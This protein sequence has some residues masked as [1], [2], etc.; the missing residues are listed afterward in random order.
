MTSL[1]RP[2]LFLHPLPPFSLSTPASPLPHPA[3][4]PN[5]TNVLVRG[6]GPYTKNLGAGGGAGVPQRESA[7]RHSPDTPHPHALPVLGTAPRLPNALS[8]VCRTR[9]RGVWGGGAS[10]R[11]GVGGEGEGG[12]GPEGQSSPFPH[13]PSL[14]PAGYVYYWVP[15]EGPAPRHRGQG[16]GS[17][18]G[19]E[20]EKGN[21]HGVA[22]PWHGLP[23]LNPKPFLSLQ[24]TTLLRDNCATDPQGLV[25]NSHSPPPNPWARCRTA[26]AVHLDGCPRHCAPLSRESDRSG[27]SLPAGSIT[28]GI[29]P[30]LVA[31]G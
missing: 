30:R 12:G 22:A 18:R 27:S 8:H 13:S 14:L 29:P 25:Y 5:S 31:P 9:G 21:A 2:P 6:P 11:R 1:T 26:G 20:N 15:R 4:P 28:G 17:G 24:D 7:R 3:P 23:T 16:G 19:K 10:G